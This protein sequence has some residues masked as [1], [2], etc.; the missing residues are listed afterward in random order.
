MKPIQWTETQRRAIG[1]LQ[2]AGM[3]AYD[4]YALSKG[5]T[6]WDGKK[7]PDYQDTGEDVQTAWVAAVARARWRL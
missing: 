4:A 7:M 5:G 6:T 1:A 2:F 3:M